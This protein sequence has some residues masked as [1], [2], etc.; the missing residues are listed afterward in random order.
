MAKRLEEA[1]LIDIFLAEFGKYVSDKNMLAS[2][3]AMLVRKPVVTDWPTDRGEV[4]TLHYR[5]T[6]SISMV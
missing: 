1:H 2:L 6:S 5:A 3:E 4:Y